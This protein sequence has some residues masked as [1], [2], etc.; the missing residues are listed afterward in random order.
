MT[1]FAQVILNTYLTM[2]NTYFNICLK[3]LYFDILI[4]IWILVGSCDLV[5]KFLAAGG[6]GG[7]IA[8]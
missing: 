1:N 8:F 2:I 7:C 5:V 6:V 3:N 4:N